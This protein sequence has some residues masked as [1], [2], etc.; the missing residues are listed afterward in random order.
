[1]PAEGTE[2]TSE[3]LSNFLEITKVPRPSG[4][5]A[6]IRAFLEAFADEH[7]LEHRADDAGNLLILRPGK[8]TRIVLQAHMD[9]VPT[10]MPGM[11]FDFTATPVEAVIEDGWVHA[12]GTTL[13]ADDGAGIA[14]AMCA[15]SDP[16]LEGTDIRCLFTTDEEVGLLGAAAVPEGWFEGDVLIN[17]DEEDDTGIVIGCAGNSMISASVEH[18][19]EDFRGFTYRI[20]LEGFQGGHSAGEIDKNRENPI[21]LAA[22]MVSSIEGARLSLLEGGNA[23][24]AIPMTASAVFSVPITVNVYDVLEPFTETLISGI[25][26]S[27]PEA[28]VT[29][30]KA[31]YMPSWNEKDTKEFLDALLSLPNGLMKRTEIGVLTSS[32]VGTAS[33]EGGR[34]SLGIMPRSSEP[35]VL[36]PLVGDIV[37]RL[38]DA[39]ADVP[40]PMTVKGW[41]GSPDGDLVRRAASVYREHY[42]RDPRVSVV[43]GGL[44]CGVLMERLPSIREA[45]CIG[46]TIMGAHSTVERMSVE[47]LAGMKAY[48]FRLIA[49]FSA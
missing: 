41:E 15:L 34:I 13:G 10:C 12:K 6:G 45:V 28:Q 47:S 43:H 49:S 44:E 20:D 25:A 33:T 17:L 18:P 42:G 37:S 1:M 8:G 27:E 7:G 46:P 9:M 29:F 3:E 35:G 5:T 38:K 14:L 30:G 23:M 48:L 11:D 16:S 32:N 36:E 40:E 2:N 4:H 21:L 19:L 22:R 31:T 24:N 39:G 26:Q